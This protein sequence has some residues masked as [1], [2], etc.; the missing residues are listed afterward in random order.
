[1]SAAS[2]TTRTCAT[3]NRD[4]SIGPAQ[5]DDRIVNRTLGSTNRCY[6]VTLSWTLG[7]AA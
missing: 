6:T 3:S 1:M 2:Y 5:G 7:Q 4:V